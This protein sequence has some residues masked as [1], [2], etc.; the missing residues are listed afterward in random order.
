L[1]N[2]ATSDNSDTT[3]D[4]YDFIRSEH[5][6]CLDELKEIRKKITA[7]S[8]TIT[9]L[10]EEQLTLS[11]HVL[12]LEEIAGKY[13][14]IAEENDFYVKAAEMLATEM[15]RKEGEQAKRV[16][17]LEKDIEDQIK[18]TRTQHMQAPFSNP[19]FFSP[20]VK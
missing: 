11:K 8:K 20:D 13:Y 5:H 7:F 10:E 18:G 12:E 6:K 15:K 17:Q 16:E 4:D 9:K 19:L 2:A 1:F 14:S 3:E